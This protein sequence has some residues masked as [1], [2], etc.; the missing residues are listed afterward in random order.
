MTECW[1]VAG[2]LPTEAQTALM[3]A[4]S[5]DRLA[6]LLDLLRRMGL[7]EPSTQQLGVCT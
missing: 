7:L 2:Q 5:L 4:R 3:D 6:S 1:A